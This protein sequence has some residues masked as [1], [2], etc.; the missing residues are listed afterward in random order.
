MSEA[1]P[2]YW[3]NETSGTLRPAIVAYLEGRELTP[4]HMRLL[5]AYLQQWMAGPWGPEPEVGQL[6]ADIPTLTTRQAF[7]C[8]L[9]RALDLGIDPL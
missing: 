8:W 4:E 6:L 9:D 1:V 2:G 7:S 5:R 3:M